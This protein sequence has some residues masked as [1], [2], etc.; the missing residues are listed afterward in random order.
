M[1]VAIDEFT[2]AP[3]KAVDFVLFTP[4]GEIH[5]IGLLYYQLQLCKKGN[6]VIY[7]GVDVPTSS[8]LKTIDQLN[9]KNILLSLVVAQE[10]EV[11]HA[12]LNELRNATNI[13]IYVSGSFIE[14]S[15]LPKLE[16]IFYAKTLFTV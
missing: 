14:Q 16:N 8:V 5:E 7:L 1:I 10:D 15:A 13:P 11:V 9:P 4:S 3:H 12:T 2:P 6:N